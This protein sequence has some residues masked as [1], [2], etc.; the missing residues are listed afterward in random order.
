M[1]PK[2]V[3]FFV[4]FLLGAFLIGLRQ[5]HA[6]AYGQVTISAPSSGAS[7]SSTSNVSTSAGWSSAPTTGL[8]LDRRVFQMT[9]STITSATSDTCYFT[10]LAIAATSGTQT[11]TLRDGSGSAGTTNSSGYCFPGGTRTSYYFVATLVYCSTG[12][13]YNAMSNCLENSG[14]VVARSTRYFTHD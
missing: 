3:V 2:F 5:A 13:S 1:K 12:S 9:G 14:N 6:T 7:Y 11:G 10:P 8:Y 4:G